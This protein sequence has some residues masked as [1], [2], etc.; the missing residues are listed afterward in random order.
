M[1]AIKALIDKI[2][3]ALKDLDQASPEHIFA[4]AES[5]RDDLQAIG[6]VAAPPPSL[7]EWQRARQLLDRYQFILNQ[8]LNQVEAGLQALG[9]AQPIY[10]VPGQD[11]LGLRPGRPRLGL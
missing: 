10:S 7:P 2:S 3:A 5:I 1:N 11:R 6:R 8:R 9:I 4:T